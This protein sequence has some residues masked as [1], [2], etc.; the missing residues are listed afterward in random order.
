[1]LAEQKKSYF[2]HL[3]KNTRYRLEDLP[4]AMAGRD[5]CWERERERERERKLGGERESKEDQAIGMSW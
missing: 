2:N 5:K 4:S 1:M 3:G